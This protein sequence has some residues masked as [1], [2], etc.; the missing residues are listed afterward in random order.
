MAALT[1]KTLGKY[2]VYE[3]I[4]RGGMA[5]VYQ[6]R[7]I[8][9]DR[10]VAIKVLHSHLAEGEDFLARFEH[11]ARAIASLQHPHIVQ[12][13]DF[14]AQ[15]DFIYMVMEFIRGGNLKLK[16]ESAHEQNRLPE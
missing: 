12:V 8:R 13:Y 5:D 16:L 11:E 4:G 1:G 9:L 3:R 6:G 7:H 10:D 14:D 2:Q 15:D